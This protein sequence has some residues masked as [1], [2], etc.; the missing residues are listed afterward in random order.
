MEATSTSIINLTKPILV[1]KPLS[2]VPVENSKGDSSDYDGP[3]LIN[4]KRAK[5]S[6]GG[7]SKK[8]RVE[9]KEKSTTTSYRLGVVRFAVMASRDPMYIAEAMRSQANIIGLLAERNCSMVI[10]LAYDLEVMRAEHADAE[11]RKE[12]APNALAEENENMEATIK[13]R[14]SDFLDKDLT[15]ERKTTL[16]RKVKNHLQLQQVTEEAE[17]KPTE[18]D[19]E[20]EIE[21]SAPVKAYEES[22]ERYYK[23]VIDLFD[24]LDNEDLLPKILALE[25]V[26][27]AKEVAHRIHEVNPRITILGCKNVDDSA[28]LAHEVPMS[29]NSAIPEAS[30]KV[31][32]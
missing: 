3:V 8:A 28:F 22:Q 1:I 7:A 2:Q 15:C 5:S 9:A 32:T 19:E 11:L 25:E 20:A 31:H 17:A 16:E 29:T 12:E 4:K 6:D 27:K 23:V 30:S 18:M 24:A 14:V 21:L 10:Q 26:D 13:Q